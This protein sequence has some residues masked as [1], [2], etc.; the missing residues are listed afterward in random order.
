VNEIILERVWLFGV[1]AVLFDTVAVI[2][3]ESGLRA[4]PEESVTILQD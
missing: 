4:E 1:E 3:I 2:A